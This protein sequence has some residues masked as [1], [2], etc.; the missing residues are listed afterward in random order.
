MRKLFTLFVL[1]VVV[2]KSF[3]AFNDY[4][5]NKTLR[6]D[7][8]H[9]GDWQSEIYSIDKLIEEK[10]WG[11]TKTNLIDPFDYGKY[12]C[13]VYDLKTNI[14]IF[15][16][17]YSTLFSEWQTTAEAKK[18]TS[19]FPETVLIPY[20][21]N[22][23]RVEFHSR[24]TKGV[25]EKKYEFT[26]DPAS[27]FVQKENKFPFPSFD[28]LINGDPAIKVD[29]V[30]IP[31]GYTKD[32][33]PKFRKD[34]QRFSTFLFNA[35]PYKQNKDKFNI[36]GIEAPSMESGTDFPGIG[37]WKN[38]LVNS[39]F[40]TFDTERYLM[41]KDNT[42]LRY[43]ASNAPYDQIV[44]IV[45]T[46][47]YGG[48]A[49]YNHY[50]VCVSDNISDEYVFTHEFGHSFAGLGDE[51]Y[52]SETSYNDFY[53]LNIE[54]WEPNLTTLVNFDIKWKSM[55]TKDVPVP[56]P[57]DKKY[58]GV[59]GVFEGGGYV[60]KGVYRPV[61]DCS[62]KSNSVNNFCPVC[63]SAIVKMIGYYTD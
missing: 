19:S 50:A 11:G 17:S 44:I 55:L 48:G 63:R 18:I 47:H 2:S 14:L 31:E 37:I 15:T 25:F 59:I 39:T 61:L 49:I 30:F 34:C 9:T 12:H 35:T 27:Y 40:Y 3:A 13:K 23:V 32:Q 54:P 33:M 21:K 51:Y 5:L 22:K 43:V 7:Y 36:R 24:N 62:M 57:N 46:D 56:T 38:T 29:I 52:D 26:V 41:T 4:F 45:N 53:P 42:T 8:F 28:I 16:Y 58:T 6:I 60:N 20:P 1:L 10:Y